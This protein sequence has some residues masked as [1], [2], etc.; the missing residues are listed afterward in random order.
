MPSDADTD[1]GAGIGWHQPDRLSQ[2]FSATPLMTAFVDDAMIVRMASRAWCEWFGSSV[3]EAVGKHYVLTIGERRERHRR[4]IELAQ[5]GVEISFEDELV[6]ALGGTRWCR[7]HLSP[8]VAGANAAAPC[9]VMIV[10]LEFTGE[11]VR[12]ELIVRQREQLFEQ[13]RDQQRNEQM[14]AELEKTR[15]L[16]DW[17]TTMLTERNEMLHLLSHEIRQPLNNAS[18][19]MQATMQAIAD[20][21]LAESTPASSALARAENVLGQVIGTLDN[22]LAA[23]TILA[24]GEAALELTDTDLPVLIRLVLADIAAD[25]RQRIVLELGTDTRTVRLHPTLMRLTLRNLLN[26]ALA[27]SP[28]E[29]AI[30]LQVS[31]SDDP[32]AIVI[33]V[34]DNGSGIPDE[35][36]P[37]LFEKGARGANSRMRSGAGLGL[38]IAHSVTKMHRGS[39][40]ALPNSPQGTIVRMTLPQGLAD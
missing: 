34:A 21:H 24:F 7:V 30:H 35:L 15:T 33:D 9:G 36:R 29:S 23:G 32:L 2:L 31:E 12:S 19:A 22:T 20:L 1:T 6:D 37:R 5:R 27:Y 18:A 40:E 13:L 38:F 14:Q 4:H 25:A 10:M 39:I 26:N 3:A 16:L 28:G 8:A 11:R 17:R